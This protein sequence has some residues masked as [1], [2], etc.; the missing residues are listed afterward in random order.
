MIEATKKNILAVDDNLVTLAELHTIL[1]GSY[2]VHLAKDAQ[3]AQSILH[4]TPID[5]ILLDLE[6]PGMSGMD[7][8]DAIHNNTSFYFIPI[9]I[10]SSHGTEDSIKRAKKKGASDF[11][12][13]PCNPK[14]LIEKINAVLK[15]ARKRMSREVVARKLNL[16]QTACTNKQSS[17]VSEIIAELEQI[18]C[19]IAIDLELAEICTTAEEGKYKETAKKISVLLKDL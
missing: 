2:E 3:L 13:K 19:E 10:V 7:F 16:L 8:L 14:T 5:L 1:E 17:R 9:I 12:V 18:Y 11:I 4:K 6:M 15:T